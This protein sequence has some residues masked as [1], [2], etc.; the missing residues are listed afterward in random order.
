MEV[1]KFENEIKT[2][3]IVN[4]Y[5]TDYF[6][7]FICFDKEIHNYIYRKKQYKINFKDEEKKGFKFPSIFLILAVLL[8]YNFF[9]K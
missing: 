6:Y 3:K 1:I 4:N 7:I 2:I 9:C 5:N 8:A